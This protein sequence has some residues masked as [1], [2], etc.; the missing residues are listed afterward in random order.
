[1]F[2]M[3][4]KYSSLLRTFITIKFKKMKKKI[5]S[6]AFGL[7]IILTAS[8]GYAENRKSAIPPQEKA[9]KAFNKEFNNSI[10]PAVYLSNGGFVL[11][12]ASDGQTITSAYNKNGN[13]IYTIK[14]YSSE[15]LLK[16]IIDV[17]QNG[18][19]S[20]GYFITT[21]KKIDQ[22]GNSSV[23]L[24]IMQSSTS[25][26]TLKVINNEVEEVEVLQKA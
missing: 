23:Y 26:K 4:L 7:A 19:D 12:A 2:V 22:P 15:S 16:N 25:Y 3:Q 13:W 5:L 17:V 6:I 18:Y 1:M 24:V 21:M 20:H 11:K 14:Q 8:T 10:V 9:I